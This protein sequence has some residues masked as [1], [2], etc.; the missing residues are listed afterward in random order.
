MALAD[1]TIVDMSN[2]SLKTGSTDMTSSTGQIFVT[3]V[4]EETISGSGNVYHGEP[5]V[6]L[7]QTPSR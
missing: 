7:A 1:Y 4:G 3:F 2:N 6:V 5:S